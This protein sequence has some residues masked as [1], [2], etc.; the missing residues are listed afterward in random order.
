MKNSILTIRN[1]RV[2]TGK[3][4]ILRGV[5]LDIE[6]GKL[7]VVMG[8]NGSG[9]ST[10]A[11]AVAGHPSYKV[12]GQIKIGNTQL[13]Q[14]KPEERVRQGIMLA[15]QTSIAI[16]GISLNNLLKT[17]FREIYPKQKMTVI[18]LH[19]KI[20]QTAQK[21]SI[22]PEMLRRDIND[23]FSGGERKKCEMLQLLIIRPKF[24]ILD[25]IDTG[26]DVDALKTVAL[27]ISELVKSG[28]GVLLIT[29]YQ[30]ILKYL[31]YDRVYVM[32][33]GKIVKVG[34]AELVKQIEEG[35]Y[36]RIS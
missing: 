35:G 21:L 4:I 33:L 29:H 3:K 6:S 11:M 9:K 27:G 2:A 17:S 34:Q 7:Q 24:A 8:P 30:R 25:E 10:L 13:H 15:F 26:L 16:P 18:E 19:K 31:D 32:R 20:E 36:A 22:P 14:L 28:T 23:G 5:N 1:L 12:S